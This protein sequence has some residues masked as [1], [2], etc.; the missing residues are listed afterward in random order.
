MEAHGVKVPISRIIA[1]EMNQEETE[2]I[3]GW[4]DLEYKLRY[5]SFQEKL[6]TTITC[7]DGTRIRHTSTST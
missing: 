6:D 2:V 3:R 1:L 5:S 4:K 7:P